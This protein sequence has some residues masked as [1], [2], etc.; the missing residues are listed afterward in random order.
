MSLEALDTFNHTEIRTCFLKHQLLESR[1]CRR[2]RASSQ[3]GDGAVQGGWRA[4][5]GLL[6]A[7]RMWG[8]ALPSGH[9]TL[10]QWTRAGHAPS[11]RW[12]SCPMTVTSP[13]PSP[14]IR[15]ASEGLA[16]GP[17]SPRRWLWADASFPTAAPPGAQAR[18][19]AGPNTASWGRGP[20]RGGF[21]GPGLRSSRGEQW[22]VPAP[23][24]LP[25]TTMAGAGAGAA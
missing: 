22:R 21:A 25:G 15:A 24:P 8:D 23:A 11:Q 5:T 10:C 2:R 18:N 16:A 9:A 20:R 19:V 1:D 3:E 17:C 13:C 7:A 12:S 6:R 14:Q 4:G